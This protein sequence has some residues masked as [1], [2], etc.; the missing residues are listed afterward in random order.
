MTDD[1]VT[2]LRAEGEMEP[3]GD[4]TKAWWS[5]PVCLE[6]ADE[7]ER[8]REWKELAYIMRNKSWW[9]MRHSVLMK[10][11]MLHKEDWKSKH[12]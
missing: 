6:A 10:F 9:A 11:E 1:I 8:L 3:I 5:N 12:V 4:G 2:R 7:I